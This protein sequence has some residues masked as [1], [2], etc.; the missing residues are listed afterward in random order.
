MARRD[1]GLIG[2][3]SVTSALI[4]VT[5]AA[6]PISVAAI[7]SIFAPAVTA[8]VPAFILPRIGPCEPRRHE[9]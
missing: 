6:V 4:P 2:A 7:T 5:P 8:T 3:S 9:Y 1:A